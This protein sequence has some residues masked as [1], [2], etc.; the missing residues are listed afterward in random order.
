MLVRDLQWGIIKGFIGFVLT[1]MDVLSSWQLDW[2][3]LSWRTVNTPYFLEILLWLGKR[4]SNIFCL[5]FNLT[6]FSLKVS[7][8][9]LWL[10]G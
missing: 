2:K 10:S 3:K 9:H 8:P 1:E 7:T 6:G 4:C 5:L